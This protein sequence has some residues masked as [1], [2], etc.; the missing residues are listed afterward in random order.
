MAFLLQG[1]CLFNSITMGMFPNGYDGYVPGRRL[2]ELNTRV[3]CIS[4]EHRSGA[5]PYST[6]VVA[7]TP[8]LRL[9]RH[10]PFILADAADSFTLAISLRGRSNVD[11]D[12]VGQLDK[13]L[14]CRRRLLLRRHAAAAAQHE[15]TC[16][17]YFKHCERLYGSGPK[18]SRSL[19]HKSGDERNA[20]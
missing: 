16:I 2:C 3:L 14:R 1:V 20:F 19:I 15:P 8:P 7:R 4:V 12:P 5:S 13:R 9:Q 11:R 17:I 10:C 6:N 18:K